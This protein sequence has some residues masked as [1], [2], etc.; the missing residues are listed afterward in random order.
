VSQG[1][2][3]SVDFLAIQQEELEFKKK[4]D[5]SFGP[6]PGKWFIERRERAQSFSEIQLCDEK[7]RE[8]RIFVEEQFRIEKLIMDEL[9]SKKLHQGKS[10]PRKKPGKKPRSTSGDEVAR[11]KKNSK[12]E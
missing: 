12:A 4:Q 9:S 11:N 2:Q 8:K 1:E 5:Q 10:R 6:S 3:A 7:E